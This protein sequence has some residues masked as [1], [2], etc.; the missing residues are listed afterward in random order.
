MSTVWIISDLHLGHEKILTYE[1][2]RM[3]EFGSIKEHDEALMDRWSDKVRPRDVVYVLGDVAWNE[4]SKKK[5]GTL[6]GIKKLILGNH[7][8]TAASMRSC[9]FR[10][11][12]MCAFIGPRFQGKELL[13]LTHVPVHP[14][15]IR[16]LVNVHGHIHSM[17]IER[18]N[19][20]DRRYYNACVEKTDFAP[21][22]LEEVITK[23]E[24][25]W[26]K[27]FRNFK[28]GSSSTGRALV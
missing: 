7:D 2:T 14:M 22:S 5:F 11:I 12:Q 3:L 6:P 13:M 26:E 8:R 9:H 15:S 4:V 25:D 21:V 28:R 24:S 27:D 17:E 18:W 23:V 16:G 10:S 1:P 19:K 20:P